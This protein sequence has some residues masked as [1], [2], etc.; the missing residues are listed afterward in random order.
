MSIAYF[1]KQL[2]SS[3]LKWN[4]LLQKLSRNKIAKYPIAWANNY[5][6]WAF[7]KRLPLENRLPEALDRAVQELTP[8]GITT[9]QDDW[10]A[11]DAIV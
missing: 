7:A 11:I 1:P 8:T 2:H 6:N 10:A 3:P 5:N 9:Y 4:T